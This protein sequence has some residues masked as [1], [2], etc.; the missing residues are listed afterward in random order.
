MG[1]VF[2]RMSHVTRPN[3]AQS[4][5]PTVSLDRKLLTLPQLQ[6]S[7]RSWEYLRTHVI[8]IYREAVGKGAFER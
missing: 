2:T 1:R 7:M 6:S 8:G 3:A 5:T 4:R